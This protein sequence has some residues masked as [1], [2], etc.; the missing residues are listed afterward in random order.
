[1]VTDKKAINIRKKLLGTFKKLEFDEPSHTYTLDGKV[2][3]SVSGK[4]K[5]FYTEF[6]NMPEAEKYSMRRGFTNKDVLDAWEGE[7]NIASDKGHRVHVFAEDYANWRYWGIGTKPK[8]QCKQCLG[9][10][11][12]YNNLPDHIVPIILELRMYNENLGYAGTADIILLNL[13]NYKIIIAD[14]KTNKQIIEED[15]PPDYL[16]HLPTKLKLRQDSFGKYTCQ[17]SFYQILLELAGFEVTHRVLVWLKDDKTN[18]KLFI[19]MYTLD[20]TK[21]LL[22]LFKQKI[23]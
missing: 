16:Y 7:S 21:E 13:K 22:T 15:F 4:I 6:D 19:K 11:D 10:I 2:L 1:M 8:V 9:V 3:P 12:F 20:I 17:F 23:I 18:K 14:W 5:S